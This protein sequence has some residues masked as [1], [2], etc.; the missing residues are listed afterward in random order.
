MSPFESEIRRRTWWQIVFLD[1]QASK[2]AG[3]GFP[4]WLAKFDTRLPL[5]I[6]DSDL[7]PTMKES[8]IEKEGATE[9]LFCSLRYEVAEALR[10]SGTFVY[11]GGECSWHVATGPELIAEKDRAIDELEA[12]FERKYI[13][14]CD[15]SIPLHLL[16]IYMSQSVICT[17]RVMAHHPR[18]Y[19]D[20]GASMPQK[21]KDMV[22]SESLK[23]LEIASMGHA[24]KE[25]KGFLWHTRVHF[26]LDAFIYILSELRFRTQG[27]MVDRAWKQVEQAY[28]DRPEMIKETRNALFFAMGNLC[29]KAWK[30]REEAG[31]LYQGTQ[32]MAP[33]RFISILRSQRRIPE[34]PA[35]S[36]SQSQNQTQQ[37][38]H[39][40]PAPNTAFRSTDPYTNSNRLID[41]ATG[42]PSEH[43]H[44]VGGPDAAENWN[45]VDFGYDMEMPEITPVDWAYWQTL[46]DGELPGF[47]ADVDMNLD[48]GFPNL[49]LAPTAGW[50]G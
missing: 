22:F 31:G 50:I 16:C 36:Q 37:L 47:S 44:Y 3:A 43:T 6:S 48:V 7:S 33:P 17:M 4:T 40:P 38:P 49:A 21:E 28:T 39:Q 34:P 19:P 23:G 11:G 35:Q 18:Q 25:V 5:N 8:P 30:A 13:R 24:R 20:K 2:L 26:Q 42:G 27:E 1:G 46:M 15:P 9:M 41:F 12:R 14:Y 45:N 29:I 10:K 32:L